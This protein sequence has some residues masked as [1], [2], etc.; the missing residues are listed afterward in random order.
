MTDAA[1]PSADILRMDVPALRAF[2]LAAF[3]LAVPGTRA[4]VNEAEPG[5][6]RLALQTR[7]EHLRPGGIVSGP[8]LMGLVD[9]AAYVAVLAHIGPVAMTVTSALNIHFLRGCRPGEV[10]AEGTL[11]RLGRKLATVEVR[12]WTDDETKPVAQAT[13]TYAIP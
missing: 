4:V 6:V 2:L 12:I 9:V 10:T 11:L 5:R 13:V 1:P 3:P 7:D 8:T